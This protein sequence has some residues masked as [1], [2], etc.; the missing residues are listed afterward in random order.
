MPPTSSQKRP[1]IL[2]WGLFVIAVLIGG[3]VIFNIID[4][5]RTPESGVDSQPPGRTSS[6]GFGGVSALGIA[7]EANALP[8]SASPAPFPTAEYRS[9]PGPTVGGVA[10]QEQR[11]IKVGALDLRVADAAKSSDQVKTVVTVKGGY[12]E[13]STISDDGTGPREAEL[14]VRVPVASFEQTIAELKGLAVVVLNEEV[15]GQDI[16]EEFVDVESDLRN[17]KAEEASYLEIMKRSGKIEEVLAVAERLADVRGRIQRLEGRKRYMENK[18]DLATIRVTLTE[19]TRVA[20]PTRTWDPLEVVRQ[21]ASE[22]VQTLQA[23][24][25]F[26]V[27]FII[28]LVA[29]LPFLAFTAFIVWFGWKLVKWFIG[30]MR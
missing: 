29:V 13:S 18:T 6:R 16:T 30:K 22:L 14:L 28:G 10:K 17:A 12:V 3:S 19:E 1:G 9:A 2:A 24:V 4:A 27:R 7:D 23:F 20:V 5:V 11:V 8:P 15:A 26:L 21:S 25:D